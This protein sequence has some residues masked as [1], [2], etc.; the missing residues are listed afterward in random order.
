MS[1]DCRTD[2]HLA[3]TVRRLCTKHEAEPQPARHL[4]TR[5]LINHLFFNPFK[6]RVLRFRSIKFTFFVNKFKYQTS[7]AI[8]YV[9]VPLLQETQSYLISQGIE[10]T[11]LKSWKPKQKYMHMIDLS[12]THN[13]WFHNS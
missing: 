1:D 5:A 2:I 4:Q 3:A 9:K 11:H 10:E 8:H 13:F 6:T 7:I 12:Y